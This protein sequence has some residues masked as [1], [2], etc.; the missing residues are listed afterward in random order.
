MERLLTPLA[1][2][3]LPVAALAVV[4]LAVGGR[5]PARRRHAHLLVG[6]ALL[7]V[8]GGF[9]GLILVG[10]LLSDPGPARALAILTPWG[11]AIAALAVLAAV[12]PRAAIGVVAP[13]ATVPIGLAAWEAVAPAAVVAWQAVAGPIDLALV[14]VLAGAAAVAARRVPRAAG[15]TVVVL[16]GVPM[17]LRLATPAGAPAGQAVIAS[18]ST[19]ALVAGVAFLLAARASATG[20]SPSSSGPAPAVGR[21]G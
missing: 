21:T 9:F 10:E 5:P 13:A 17:A 11:V 6:G 8:F 12:A 14:Y 3:V 18:L 4:H 15:W 20:Q 16:A 1:F 2:A 7:G 19:P